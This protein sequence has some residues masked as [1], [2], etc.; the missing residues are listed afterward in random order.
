[1]TVKQ[2]KSNRMTTLIQKPQPKTFNFV[3]LLKQWF[4]NL[5]INQEQ[6][7]RLIVRWIPA[8]CPFTRE[9]RA[10][11]KVIVRIPT[12]CKFNPLYE[13]LIGLRFRALCFLADQCGI[14]I[15]PYCS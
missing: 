2:N 6:T 11:G 15:T 3:L 8:Q 5:E 12:L 4:H 14:D 10:F 1:M 13:E 9:I 7:A